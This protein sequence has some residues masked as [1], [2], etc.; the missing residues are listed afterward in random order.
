MVIS[1][2]IFAQI[3]SLHRTTKLLMAF[4]ALLKFIFSYINQ[5]DVFVHT[6]WCWRPTVSV[7]REKLHI[8]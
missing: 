7:F 5:S 2:T 8:L 6:A 4:C 1:V 3:I